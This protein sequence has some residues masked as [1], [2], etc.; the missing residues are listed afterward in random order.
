MV[1]AVG[2]CSGG[3]T[4]PAPSPTATPSPS[5]TP[6][7][8]A[9]PLTGEELQDRSV[10]D[11]PVVAVKIENTSAA[12]PQAGL[13]TADIVFEELTEGGVTRFL[14]LFQSEIPELVGP[15]RSGRP[16]DTAVLPAYDA[17]FFISGARPDVLNG[18]RAAGVDF[19]GEDG[20][21][22]FREPSRRAPHNV[23]ALGE[24]LF[25]VATG[26]VPPA[27]PV[28]W[29]FEEDVP[30]GAVAC[31]APCEDDP[32]VE[33]RVAM[34][35][36]SV[37]GFIYDADAGVYRREQGGTPQTVTGPGQVGAAN[38]LVL[39]TRTRQEGCCDPAGNPLNVT[40]TVGSGQALILRDGNL[41][42]GKWAKAAPDEH[43]QVFGPDGQPFRFKPGPTWAMFAPERAVPTVAATE[44]AG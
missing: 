40:A 5:P 20:T 18:L 41:Y 17:M 14:S 43:V 6:Q 31:P 33:I 15:I 19:R 21:V 35:P 32:G 39:A 34:S 22:L 36:Q 30:D 11:R 13:D 8:F 1:G 16:E 27:E 37:T 24:E 3:D 44:D 38:V 42:V 28:G 9:A 29:R 7:T 25:E 2:A 10:L 26:E 4:S 12:R 23:F